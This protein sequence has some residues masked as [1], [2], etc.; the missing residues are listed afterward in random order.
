M[1]FL[2]QRRVFDVETCLNMS[3][4]FIGADADIC[5]EGYFCPLGTTDPEPC[6]KGTYSNSTGIDAELD[7]IL[8]PAGSYC[9]A[10]GLTEPS[11]LC[12]AG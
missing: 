3:L 7:C 8:C 6:P 11:G 5:P 4:V 2:S 1:T 9:D 10:V 12:A